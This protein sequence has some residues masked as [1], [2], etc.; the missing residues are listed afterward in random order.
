MVENGNA[1]FESFGNY[2]WLDY[3][4]HKDAWLPVVGAGSNAQK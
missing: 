3:R 4:K 1:K 2:P